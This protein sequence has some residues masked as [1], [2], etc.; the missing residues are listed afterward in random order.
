LWD[1]SAGL[2]P[3]LKMIHPWEIA[4][5]PFVFHF[6]ASFLVS[7]LPLLTDFLAD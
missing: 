6:G 1:C 3:L 7:S 2:N 5:E 4:L